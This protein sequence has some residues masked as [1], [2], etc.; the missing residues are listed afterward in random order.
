[1]KIMACNKAKTVRDYLD[2]RDEYGYIPLGKTIPKNTRVRIKW[3]CP[4]DHI[5]LMSYNRIMS[6]LTDYGKPCRICDPLLRYEI[7][8]YMEFKEK[9]GYTPLIEFAPGSVSYPIL[10]KC[11][12]GH[13]FRQSFYRIRECFSDNRI[14]CPEC[15]SVSKRNSVD[16]Y[17]ELG[18]TKSFKLISTTISM[19]DSPHKWECS[20]SHTFWDSYYRVKNHNS[21]CLDCAKNDPKLHELKASFNEIVNGEINYVELGV[22]CDIFFQHEMGKICILFATK[23]DKRIKQIDAIRDLKSHKSL[24]IY[25]KKG[26]IPT[27]DDLMGYLEQ[28]KV[29]SHSTIFYQVEPSNF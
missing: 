28:L 20:K 24:T 4:N 11:P 12:K 10:W 7:E 5:I 18:E 14:P 29:E 26:E 23:K 6:L 25:H 8:S 27:K 17:R 21:N 3:R 9:H 1:M 15:S 19:H 22:S 16:S 2:V 13:E